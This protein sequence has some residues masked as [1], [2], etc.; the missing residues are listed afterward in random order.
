MLGWQSLVTLQVDLTLGDVFRLLGSTMEALPL[1]G[2]R[3]FEGNPGLILDLLRLLNLDVLEHVEGLLVA[4]LLHGLLEVGSASFYVAQ[5]PLLHPDVGLRVVLR[6]LLPSGGLLGHD[7]VVLGH[8][9]LQ[10]H[11]ML[12][13]AL[14]EGGVALVDRLGILE[15]Y[16]LAREAPVVIATI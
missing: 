14:H 7:D 16:G 12:L 9:V 1:R 8:L 3:T 4:K 15:L 13:Y 2:P 11:A 5:G 6:Q 10:A